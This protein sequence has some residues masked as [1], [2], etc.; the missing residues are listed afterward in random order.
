MHAGALVF[1]D[2]QAA[3]RRGIAGWTTRHQAWLFFPF[4]ALEAV[5]LHVVERARAG[6]PGSG[7][8]VS[9]RCCCSS[10]SRR[11]ASW[12]SAR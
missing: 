6:P 4:L 8:A 3:G 12:W 10:T 11:T 5:N 9:R 1:D 7:T 2:S